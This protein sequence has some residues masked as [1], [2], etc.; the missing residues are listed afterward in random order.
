MY[1]LTLTSNV[2]T[3][4]D[5]GSQQI[6]I[7]I[8]FG[9]FPSLSTIGTRPMTIFMLEPIKNENS[10]FTQCKVLFLIFVEWYFVKEN[11]SWNKKVNWVAL[12][13]S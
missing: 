11:Y 1:G 4:S 12:S 2:P 5:Y 9:N 3:Q 13:N 8:I 10:N 6:K 7:V